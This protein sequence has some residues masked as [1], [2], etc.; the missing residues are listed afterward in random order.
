MHL[1]CLLWLFRLLVVAE[2]VSVLILLRMYQ[3]IGLALLKFLPLCGGV[4][5]CFF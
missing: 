1:S 5:S 3:I 4:M 2:L